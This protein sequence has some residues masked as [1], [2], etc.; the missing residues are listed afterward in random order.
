MISP[1][2]VLQWL[3]NL[4]VL[5]LLAALA[6]YVWPTR[7]RYDHVSVDGN[8]YPVRIDRFTGDG[9]ML[10]PD[11]GWVPVEGDSG[12]GDSGTQPAARRS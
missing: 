4:A 10:V 12:D 11:Q 3:R 8:T 6:V 2:R 5:L 9:D 1:R 7:F